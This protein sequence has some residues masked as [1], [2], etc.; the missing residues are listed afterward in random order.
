[1][2]R[3][4]KRFILFNR[5]IIQNSPL[6]TYSS[7]LLFS[8]DSSI[9][10]NT[11]PP[12]PSWIEL[13]PIIGQSW[14]L[15]LQT[16]E[17]HVDRITYVEYSRNGRW[18]ASTSKDNTLRIWDAET[19]ALQ[20]TFQDD[21]SSTGG[22]ASVTFSH[23]SQWLAYSFQNTV[24]VLNAETGNLQWTLEGHIGWVQS[25]KFAYDNRSLA[26]ASAYNG[27]RIIRIWDIDTGVFY[28]KL[29]PPGYRSVHSLAFANQTER[30]ASCTD[31][32]IHIW[33]TRTGA[34]EQ[35]LED[36]TDRG[37]NFQAAAFSHDDSQLVCSCSRK[38]LIWHTDSWTVHHILD[39]DTAFSTTDCFTKAL[40]WSGDSHWVA[41][42]S[43]DGSVQIWDVEAGMLRQT[44]KGHAGWVESLTFSHDSQRLASAAFQDNIIRVWDVESSTQAS[45]QDHDDG[46]NG[47]SL[48][49]DGL[50]LAAACGNKTARIWNAQTGNIRWTLGGHLGPVL[51]VV[52]SP[53]CRHLAS[54]SADR[55]P[56]GTVRLWCIETGSLLHIFR[57]Y[58]N[59]AEAVFS[60]D[61]FMLACIGRSLP[62]VH[63][64]EVETGALLQRIKDNLPATSVMFLDNSRRVVGVSSGHLKLGDNIS[65]MRKWVWN[66][67]I[68]S[69]QP[70]FANDSES[71]ESADLVHDRRLVDTTFE[72]TTTKAWD[73]KTP[74]QQYLAN[75]GNSVHGVQF[76]H[77]AK[78]VATAASDNVIRIW[79]SQEGALQ[80]E[81]AVGSRV[82]ILS[83]SPDG[84]ILNTDIGSFDIRSL[85]WS[86]YRL[87]G[88][89]SWV[90]WKGD[91]LLWLPPEYR[92]ERSM[93]CGRTIVLPILNRVVIIRVKEVDNPFT[94]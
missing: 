13:G 30:L 47:L 93:I 17:G 26:S 33:D 94:P 12:Q 10:K 42:G 37:G 54:A 7:A 58:P 34:L 53:D 35:Q 29:D 83:F 48:S 63:I 38:V 59:G 19:G 8:S 68:A 73:V 9:I 87:R 22:I 40:S 49:S 69:S 18:M 60:P 81:I 89:R 36:H 28:R 70:L 1:M 24:K 72:D 76:S 20:R 77:D 16:L 79:S 82:K 85:E 80:Q 52:F 71:T 61:S 14:I 44:L 62:E 92:S 66:A 78:L 90:T 39:G 74:L 56:D 86:P 2:M 32:H 21:S 11:F 41:S 67:E 4:A 50:W 6:Q 31:D 23:D 91:D 15:S 65:A 27:D 55:F 43:T 84:S 51:S 88:D 45:L 46:I 3:D 64:W 57:G 25:I 5:H 75:S